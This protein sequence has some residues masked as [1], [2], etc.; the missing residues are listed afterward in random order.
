MGTKEALVSKVKVEQ[1]G[2]TETVE[3]ASAAAMGK[4]TV[5][6]VRA[7]EVVALM[8]VEAMALVVM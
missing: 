4:V 5:V 1:K 6:A 8:E 3:P 2:A 7:V